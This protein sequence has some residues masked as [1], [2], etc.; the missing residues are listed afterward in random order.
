MGIQ[1]RKH[2]LPRE[3]YRGEIAAVF[4]LCI[5][6][7]L[8][9]FGDN[10]LV[11]HFIDILQQTCRRHHCLLLVY[12]DHLHLVLRGMDEQ[13]DL[14]RA[15]V[16]FKQQSGFWLARNRPGYAWQKDFYD[17]VV[18]K[19]GDLKAQVRYV[20]ENPVRKGL[21]SSW[22]EYPFTGSIGVNLCEVLGDL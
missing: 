10:E 2:R 12:S 5:Q 11:Q 3:S 8:P 1:E 20:A 22:S 15:V 6:D 9:A 14:R 16:E 7:R 19:S 13:A 18:R 17:H 4:T 21:V